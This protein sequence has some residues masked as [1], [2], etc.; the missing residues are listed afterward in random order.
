METH[1]IIIIILIAVILLFQLR[2]FSQ[3]KSKISLFNN[4]IPEQQSFSTIKIYVRE[5]E[6]EK[7]SLNEIFDEIEQYKSDDFDRRSRR[8]LLK[9]KM[10]QK[11][12]RN[13]ENKNEETVSAEYI[14]ADEYAAL[15]KS[16]KES[17]KLVAE[18]N[19]ASEEIIQSIKQ[20]SKRNLF[21][22]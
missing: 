18:I 19:K 14:D 3:A 10:D 12:K 5:D 13:A 9:E 8:K 2:V 17:D 1:D 6:I 4:V 15:N 20:K 16:D 22:D 21:D 11:K 7:V